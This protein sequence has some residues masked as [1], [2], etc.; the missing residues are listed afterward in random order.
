VS[1]RLA[2]IGQ[3]RSRRSYN[4]TSRFDRVNVEIGRDWPRQA[5]DANRRL[6]EETDNGDGFKDEDED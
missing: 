3:P 5:K 1:S 6:F 2:A 4:A